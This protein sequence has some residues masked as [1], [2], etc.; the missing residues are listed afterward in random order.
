VIDSLGTFETDYGYTQ[1]RLG[2]A[3]EMT[4]GTGVINLRARNYEPPSL[5]TR[6]YSWSGKLKQLLSL[7]LKCY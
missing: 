2:Q 5:Y 6:G 3:G 1:K 4:D 7:L